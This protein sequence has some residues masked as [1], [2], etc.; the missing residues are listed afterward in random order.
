MKAT[1]EKMIKKIDKLIPGV[2]GTINDYTK[3]NS[4]KSLAAAILDLSLAE[5]ANRESHK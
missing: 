1:I 3:V 5:K 2:P 4:I